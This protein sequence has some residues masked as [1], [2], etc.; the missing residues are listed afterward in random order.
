M[1]I[2]DSKKGFTLIEI[3]LAILIISVGV[4]SVIGLTGAALDTSK[5]MNDDLNAISFSD[6]VFGYF[7]SLTNWNEIP[8]DVSFPVDIPDYDG[9]T[10]RLESSGQFE[11]I[12]APRFAGNADITTYT[13]TYRIQAEEPVSGELKT[14]DIDV[15]PGYS[16]EGRP[17]KF[18]TE[19]YNWAP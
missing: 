9:G 12:V 4:L 8:P 10:Y 13:V 14:L 17:R 18:H 6:M 3:S 15:W 2:P 7:N 19:F 11:N 16:E 5:R 1:T